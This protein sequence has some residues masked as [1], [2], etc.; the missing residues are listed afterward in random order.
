VF[1]I[2]RWTIE[3]TN[4]LLFQ[5]KLT[6]K[7]V[8][9]VPGV[10]ST[11]DEES[12]FITTS[13][14]NKLN[15]KLPFVYLSPSL[16]RD[17]GAQ[18]TYSFWFKTEPGS[19]F[20]TVLFM[21]GDKTRA[22]F[23]NVKKEALNRSIKHPVAFCPM[24]RA[25]MESGGDL[26]FTSQVNVN[27]DYNKVATHTVKNESA[28]DV[29]QWN[30]V[31][32]SYVDGEL[33]GQE[34]VVMC[35]IWYNLIPQQQFFQGSSIKSNG[36]NLYV[37]PEFSGGDGRNAYPKMTHTNGMRNLTYHNWAFSSNDV[38]DMM[39][40]QSAALKKPYIQ[41]ADSGNSDFMQASLSLHEQ[42]IY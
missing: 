39:A 19:N 1:W 3:T 10:K 41:K 17:G 5:T 30:L 7:S 12:I 38:H 42:H 9:V 11:K 18:F 40:K 26:T 13:V 25:K 28:V 36:G 8:V 21:R 16:D 29:T 20:D 31:C 6:N 27:D 4:S 37:I 22:D 14:T 23:I 15:R 34:R 24:I 32:V 33:H 2:A 35:K